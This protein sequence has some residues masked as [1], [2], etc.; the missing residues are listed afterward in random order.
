MFIKNEYY[1]LPTNNKE[2]V[3]AL[4]QV[5]ARGERSALDFEHRHFNK[6][7]E[8]AVLYCLQHAVDIAKG[9]FAVSEEELPDSSITLSRALIEALIWAR[10]VT[11]S[12]ENAVEFTESPINEVKRTARKNISAG[13]MHLIDNGTKKDRTKEFMDS[14][15]MKDIPS[16]ITIKDAAK[17]GG[18]ERLYS[19]IYGFISITAHGRACGLQPELETKDE[20][21]VSMCS[22]LGALEC[23]EVIANDWITQ[24]KQTPQNVLTDLLGL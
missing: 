10:Y 12:E 16:R 4:K 22:A 1:P 11:I 7:R 6:I 9:C 24:R 20:I 23:I 5:I 17:A 3:D 21:Y 15:F 13:Y 2:V 8:K 18:L 19:E 14:E